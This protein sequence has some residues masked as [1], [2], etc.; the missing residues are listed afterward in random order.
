VPARAQRSEC[1]GPEIWARN[2]EPC[3]RRPAP[4]ESAHPLSGRPLSDSARISFLGRRPNRLL[5]SMADHLSAPPQAPPP[6]PCRVSRKSGTN[7]MGAA[8]TAQISAPALRRGRGTP[9]RT[10]RRASPG[11][12]ST[13][14]PQVEIGVRP[15]AAATPAPNPSAAAEKKNRIGGPGFCTGGKVRAPRRPATLLA[16][17]MVDGPLPASRRAIDAEENSRGYWRSPLRSMGRRK[18]PSPRKPRP[19]LPPGRII[20]RAAALA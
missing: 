2:L 16:A 19:G 6:R 20:W 13:V 4:H 5:P 3:S 11:C 18:T 10:A 17:R 9:G 1:P 7:Q 12:P 15:R 8:A 14:S